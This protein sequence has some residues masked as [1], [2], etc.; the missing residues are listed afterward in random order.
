MITKEL[1]E[2]FVNN[3]LE[4]KDYGQFLINLCKIAAAH[5][6]AQRDAE[7]IGVGMQPIVRVTPSMLGVFPVWFDGDWHKSVYRREGEYGT[8]IPLYTA[9]Q[10]AAA[11]LQ[12]AEDERALGGFR[13][14]FMYSTTQTKARITD[15]ERVN[16]GLLTDAARYRALKQRHAYKMVRSLLGEEGY[17]SHKA[18]DQIDAYADAAL[19]EV[20]AWDAMSQEKKDEQRL[21]A[22]AAA[23][24]EQT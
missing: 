6:A 11:R 9:T 7:L 18:S 21:A 22:I 12:G 14:G 24:K 16:Q 5:G 2:Q 1:V 13:E 3:A 19:A 10:L 17:S 20:S 4:D 15:L 8:G 23:T